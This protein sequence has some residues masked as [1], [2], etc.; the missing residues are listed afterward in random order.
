MEPLYYQRPKGHYKV[1]HQRLHNREKTP[2]DTTLRTG[3]G[4]T[5]PHQRS[6]KI[7]AGKNREA[8]KGPSC[9]KGAR[10]AQSADHHSRRGTQRYSLLLHHDPSNGLCFW[11][12]TAHEESRD[13]S[14]RSRKAEQ[15]P[16]RH[17]K[18]RCGK[19]EPPPTKKVTASSVHPRESSGL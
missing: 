6:Q 16:I 4:E 14:S 5:P 11:E 3:G 8:P 1:L 18:G 2:H 7:A 12:H 15:T 19:R 17:P 10:S 9:V 13:R